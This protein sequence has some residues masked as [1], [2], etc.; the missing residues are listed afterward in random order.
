MKS[1]DYEKL[2]KKAADI[3]KVLPKHL[4][5]EAIKPILTHLLSGN[6]AVQNSDAHKPLEE[7]VVASDDREKFYLSY[8]HD[9]P[10]DNVLLI[11]AW[12][13]SQYGVYPL[14]K[15]AVL[16][17]AS[18]AGLTISDR[19]DN[20]MRYAKENGKALFKKQGNGWQLTLT[21]EAALK[22]KYCV[23][24]GKKPRPSEE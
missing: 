7:S 16:D 1:T 11:A 19:P 6:V 15:S 9:K 10:R 22:D 12:F 17:E 13:Y 20:T 3:V 14:T 4:Q 2:A 24:K 21:G 18:D 23:K 8:D 5:A